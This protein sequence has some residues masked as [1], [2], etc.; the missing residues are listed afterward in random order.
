MTTSQKETVPV[1]IHTSITEISHAI[2]R[3][4]TDEAFPVAYTTEEE[5]YFQTNPKPSYI[6]ELIKQSQD[7]IDLQHSLGRTKIVLIT[8][9]GTTVPLENNTVRFIDNFSAGT[10]G[11][12]SAEQF[13]LNGYSVI[14]LHREFSLTPFNRNF[15]HGT[16]ISFLDY[17]DE[18]GQINSKYHDKIMEMK[19]LYDRFHSH[20]R[21][22]L[23]LP[24]TTVNQYL[25]SLK[26]IARLMNSTGSLFYLAAAVSDFFI[27]FSRL[28]EHKIQS[29]DYKTDGV[30]TST[31]AV[32]SK[33]MKKELAMTTPEGQLIIN[34]DPVPKFLR[35]LV[36][37]WATQAML[38]SFKLE[39]DQ[40]ILI[41]KSTFALDRY[42][43]QLVIGNLLQTRHKEVV[44]VSPDNRRGQ[45]IHLDGDHKEL[46]E[47]MIPE[48]IKRHD[49]WIQSQFKA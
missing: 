3:T 16:S 24:F 15:T 8:S 25:W 5:H 31:G 45:W 17:F 32:T 43:H 34:L 23:L 35:R 37:S 7:F 11:A 20:E 21:K 44:F 40:S 18:R 47:L 29:R 41:E 28:P 36:E 4:I 49:Q 33:E 26:S 2:D 1:R 39:T 42:N 10:R 38:V 9:G 6:D 46:E 12:S 22:L 30:E 48:V 14:F 19:T 13:L 27:P